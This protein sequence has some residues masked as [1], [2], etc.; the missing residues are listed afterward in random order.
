MA[1]TSIWKITRWLPKVI[2]YTM[3][4]WKTKNEE[5]DN[6][7]EIK[8]YDLHNVID[9]AKSDYKTEKQFFVTGINCDKESALEEMINVKEYYNK[10][11]GILGFHA[12]QSFKPGEVTPEIAH[13][14][15]IKLAKEMWGDRFQVVVSTHLNTNH[16]HSHFVINS[17]SFKDGLRYYNTHE[18]YSIFRHLSDDLCREYGLNVIKEKVTKKFMNYEHFYEKSKY[19]NNYEINAKRD[20]DLAIRQAYSYDDFIFLMKKLNYQVIFRGEKI[21]IRHNNYNRNIRIERRFGEEYS[22]ENIRRRILEEEAVRVPFIENYYRKVRYPFVRRHKHAKT[23]GFVALYYH[24]CYLLK[25]FPNIPQQRLPISIRA[26]VAKMNELSEEAKLLSKYKIKTNE[27]L[28]E[29]IS[30]TIFKIGMLSSDR[31]KLWT[32]RRISKDDNEKRKICNEISSLTNQ[33]D[34]L[35][36]EVSRCRDIEERLPKIEENLCELDY[37]EEQEKNKIK[38]KNSKRKEKNK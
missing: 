21:S 22:I 6:E 3:Q 7:P 26:D 13:E 28:K 10:T 37:Q 20:L 4:E 2:K 12:I 29:F 32:K 34:E 1:T 25:I 19:T 23:K 27:D 33:I 30:E 5:F 31:E 14:I 36:K 24:Y 38:D 18:N 9:Y 11:D 16:I 35:R 17:V 8:Y 15:G